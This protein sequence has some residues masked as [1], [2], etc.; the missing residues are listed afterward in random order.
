MNIGEYRITTLT[1]PPFPRAYNEFDD[2]PAHV[3]PLFY[4][5]LD[6]WG[7]DG[8][9]IGDDTGIAPQAHIDQLKS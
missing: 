6:G 1:N 8:F 2:I 9:I 7:F 5:A 3:H 4:K